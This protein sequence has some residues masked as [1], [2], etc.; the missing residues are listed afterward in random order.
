MENCSL[1]ST[2]RG[3]LLPSLHSADTHPQAGIFLMPYQFQQAEIKLNCLKA[4]V[5]LT[6]KN[7]MIDN[8]NSAHLFLKIWAFK[9]GGESTTETIVHLS[10]NHWKHRSNRKLMLVFAQPAS[11]LLD[12]RYS[13]LSATCGMMDILWRRVCR[14]ISEV[15]KPSIRILPSGSASRNRADIRE[16]L[17]APVRPTMPTCTRRR[18]NILFSHVC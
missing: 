4:S 10:L 15:R 6:F 16:L 17:P 3:S 2:G 11:C 9:T 8:C 7:P 12:I 13:G 5:C 14:P 18:G 1:H